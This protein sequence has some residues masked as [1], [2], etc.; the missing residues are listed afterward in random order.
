MITL[1]IEHD[2]QNW[3]VWKAVFDEHAASRKKHGCISEELFRDAGGAVRI[4][5]VMRWPDRSSAEAFL[6][7]PSLG[8]AMGRAG[9]SGAPRIWFWDTVET[10]AF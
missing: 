8:E 3:D 7:D 1:V 5:N 10:T 9:V 6:A 4:M 2:M